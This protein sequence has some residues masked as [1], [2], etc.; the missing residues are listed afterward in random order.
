MGYSTDF[1]GE[2]K[3]KKPLTK[4]QI[5]KLETFLGEDCRDHE[6]W[7]Q[8]DLT[9][10]DLKLTKDQ[11]GLKWDGSEK[12]YDLVDKVNLIINEMHKDFPDFELEG[13]L[14]AQGED[15]KDRWYLAI[16]NGFACK[17]KTLVKTV[18]CPEC[19]HEFLVNNE[20]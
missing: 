4:K 8:L 5:E 20:I 19:N 13:Q 1:D 11:S 2:L 10:I 6:E 18:I 14:T 7:G 15:M 9:Y 3:F 12:T 17:R 16:E